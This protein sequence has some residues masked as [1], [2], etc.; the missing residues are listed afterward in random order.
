MELVYIDENY[1][2]YLK[3]NSKLSNVL[4]NKYN[5]VTLKSRPYIGVL[6]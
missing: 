4:D 1:I 2:T 3:N 5:P 6:F